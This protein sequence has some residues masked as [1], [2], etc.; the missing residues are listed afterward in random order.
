M[1]GLGDL[2]REEK[3]KLPGVKKG[4]YSELDGFYVSDSFYNL[5]MCD[6]HGPVSNNDVEMVVLAFWKNK[7]QLYQPKGIKGR[8]SEALGKGD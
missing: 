2:Y 7:K 1:L 6:H 4:S 5:V 8:V 3:A